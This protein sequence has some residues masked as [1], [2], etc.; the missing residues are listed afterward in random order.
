MK[1]EMPLCQ[2][3]SRSDLAPRLLSLPV[4]SAAVLRVMAGVLCLLGAVLGGRAETAVLDFPIRWEDPLPEWIPAVPIEWEDRDF[5]RLEVPLVGIPAGQRILVT[6]VFREGETQRLSAYWVPEGENS[7]ISIVEN[8]LEGLEGW[9]QRLLLLTPELT[10]RPGSLI[11]DSSGSSRVVQR[12]VF[13]RLSP[14]Q[15]FTLPAKADDPIFAPGR[16][17]YFQ[18]DLEKPGLPPPDAWF[19][20]FSEAWLQEKAE[21][22]EGG[23]EFAVDIQ[24]APTSAVL[25][26]ELNGR[27]GVPE[28][29]VNGRKVSGISLEIPSWRD[30]AYLWENHAGD[31]VYAG[32]RSG[33]VALPMGLLRAGEN[34]FTFLPAHPKDALRS[35]RLELFFP[36]ARA[37]ATTPLLPAENPDLPAADDL[38]AAWQSDLLEGASAPSSPL[39]PAEESGSLFR[40]SLF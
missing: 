37:A 12:L 14:G 38:P 33:W 18:T 39:A 34:T 5:R 40:T 16:G 13:H 25:R 22:L 17:F 28:L 7:G 24:P 27:G 9:N 6:V 2:Q 1:D 32:W 36:T 8:L 20:K 19:G 23:L 30:P 11:F 31:F 21:P 3:E 10:S 26:F 15:S 35:T 4:T 29:W